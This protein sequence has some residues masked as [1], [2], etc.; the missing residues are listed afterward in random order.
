MNIVHPIPPRR[1]DD[2]AGRTPRVA[3]ATLS[4]FRLGPPAGG[5]KAIPRDPRTPSAP[6]DGGAILS[7][8]LPTSDLGENARHPAAANANP[9]DD[10][11][12]TCRPVRENW[13]MRMDYAPPPAIAVEPELEPEVE[14]CRLDELAALVRTL[15]YGEFIELVAAIARTGNGGPITQEEFP[16]ALL[17][18]MER[19]P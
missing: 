2:G 4:L 10:G 9:R 17:L 13:T 8:A 6:R 11:A 7:T 1:V 16:A 19:R 18:A 3:R 15:R 12:P 14:P 5:S